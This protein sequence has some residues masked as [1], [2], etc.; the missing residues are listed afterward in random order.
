MFVQVLKVLHSFLLYPFVE[1]CNLKSFNSFNLCL[2][3]DV[4]IWNSWNVSQMNKS[5]EVLQR[6]KTFDVVHLLVLELWINPVGIYL[7]KVNNGNTR[8]RCEICSQLT[9]KTPECRSGV[10]TVKFE[11]ISHLVLVFLLLT[12]CRK[13]LAGRKVLTKNQCA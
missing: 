6:N 11:H 1:L 4:L 3:K 9:I 8:A 12:L 10:F 13:L 2:I 7:L 5:F